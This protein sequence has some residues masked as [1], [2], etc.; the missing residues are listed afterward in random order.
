MHYH[1][2]THLKKMSYHSKLYEIH[3]FAVI[4]HFS[5]STAFNQ[6]STSLRCLELEMQPVCSQS[7]VMY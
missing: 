6:S 3:H 2:N 7:N 5:H 4:V 1:Y